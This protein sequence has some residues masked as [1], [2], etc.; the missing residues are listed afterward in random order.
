MPAEHSA[1]LYTARSILNRSKDKEF[2]EFVYR[3]KLFFMVDNETGYRTLV[4][5][6][7]Y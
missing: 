2:V 4:F 1:K 3:G 6:E 7:D 5:P